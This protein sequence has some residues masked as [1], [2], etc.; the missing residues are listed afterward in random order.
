MLAEVPRAGVEETIDL[1]ALLEVKTSGNLT[2][3]ETKLL[4]TVLRD[5]RMRFVTASSAK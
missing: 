2:P 4:H 3:E 1:I 5:L